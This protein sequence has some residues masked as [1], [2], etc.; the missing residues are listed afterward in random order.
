MSFVPDRCWL[1]CVQ[2]ADE[3][4]AFRVFDSQNYRGR[5]L[6]PHDLL[7]AYHLGEMVGAESEAMQTAVVEGWERIPDA[8]LDRLFSSYL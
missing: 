5:S 2:T 4:E 7:K 6:M 8:D 1:V 3:D